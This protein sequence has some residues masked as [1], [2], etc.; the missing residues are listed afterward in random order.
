M[1][2]ADLSGTNGMVECPKSHP[3]MLAGMP[4]TWGL[5]LGHLGSFRLFAWVF[6]SELGRTKYLASI[7][8]VNT[9]KLGLR[10]SN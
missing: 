4:V 10:R 9:E 5:L 6:W 2:L 1:A 8:K 3:N 7:L